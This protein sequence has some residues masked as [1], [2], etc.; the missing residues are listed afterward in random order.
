MPN[1]YSN[2]GFKDR[3]HEFLGNLVAIGALGMLLFTTL[4]FG[5]VEAWSIA[6]FGVLI[7][8]LFLLWGIKCILERGVNLTLPAEAWPILALVGYGAIQC[9][10]HTDENG[11]RF[12]ISLD[13]EATR[14][15]MEVTAYLLIALILFSSFLVSLRRLSWLQHFLVIF[16]LGL[17]VFGLVQKFTWNGKY[18]WIITPS[19]LAVAPLGPFV[20]RNHFAGYLEMIIPIPVSLILVR[21]VRSELMLFYG[22]AAVMMSISVFISLSRGG[23]ISLMASLIFIAAYGIKPVMERLKGEGETRWGYVLAPR[24]GAFLLIALTIGIGVWWVGGDAV[25]ERA[26]RTELTGEARG[27]R[28]GKE[29]FY[30]SRG[31]IWRDTM[32]MIRANWMTGIGFGAFETAYPIYS[33][34]DGSL[35]ISQAHNDYLQVLADCGVIGGLIAIC[36]LFVLF[37]NFVRGLGHPDQRLNGLVLGCGGGIIAM[38]VHSLFD[39]NLQLPSNALLFLALTAVISNI[40]SSVNRGKFSPTPRGQAARFSIAA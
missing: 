1:I 26:E 24:I 27:S 10:T 30:Q 17:A 35:I 40:G 38:L 31:W 18:Y 33:Q 6:A 9:I 32:T 13:V 22:F 14:L 23:M 29:T 21:A 12:A 28:P 5:T 11:K 39:F 4:A 34:S 37:R 8:A 36:F 19:S 20:N 16:G 15:T 3:G 25:I 2:P 7:T